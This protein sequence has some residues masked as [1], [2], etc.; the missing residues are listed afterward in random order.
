MRIETP[1]SRASVRR[2]LPVAEPPRRAAAPADPG[3]PS[4]FA[5]VLHKLGSDI[6]Q[7]ERVVATAM[8]SHQA[9]DPASLLALQAG[10]YKY[11]E[12]VDLASKLVDRA[13]SA[14]KTVLQGQ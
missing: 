14:V 9:H 13:T 11:V 6:D 8:T 1:E 5:R 10:V 12:A 4:P 7:G 3:P 2:A